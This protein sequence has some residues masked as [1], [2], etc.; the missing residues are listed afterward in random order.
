MKIKY[1][2]LFLFLSN[3]SNVFAQG[4]IIHKQTGKDTVV[5]STVDS[6]TF[7]Q[8]LIVHKNTGIKDS[9]LLSNIDSLTYDPTINHIT[10]TEDFETGTKTA[11]A[12]ADV[13][14]K[15]GVWN[16]N[17][18][19]IG[20]S[21]ADVKNGTKSVRMRNTGRLTMKFSLTSGAGTVT[22]KHAIYGSLDLPT[23]WQLWY[24]TDDGA[25]W[26]QKILQ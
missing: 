9:V 20:N 11:Y 23:K 13:T 26:Q 2:V 6:I 21:T 22:I 18:A 10:T 17:D 24:S 14:L 3:F 1:L 8:S 15:T 5:I 12:A 19:L 25:N 7:T 16:L 4:L